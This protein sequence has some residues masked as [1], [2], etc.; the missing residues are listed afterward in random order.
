M[1]LNRRH[2]MGTSAAATALT[3]MPTRSWAMDPATSDKRIIQIFLRGG[4]DGLALVP[5]IG[6]PDYVEARNGIATNEEDTLDLDGFFRVDNRLPTLKALY[7]AGDAAIF[8]AINSP[9]EDRSH[10]DAMN[11]LEMGGTYPNQYSTGWLGRTLQATSTMPDAVSLGSATPPTLLGS[12]TTLTYTPSPLDAVPSETL[13]LLARS[14]ATDPLL[15]QG[16]IDGE[17]VQAI[18]ESVLSQIPGEERGDDSD[19]VSLASLAGAFLAAEEGPR[20][21]TLDIGGWDTHANQRGEMSQLLPLLDATLASLQTNLGAAWTDT[22]I[23]VMSEFGRTVAQNGTAG[24]DHGTGGLALALGGTVNGGRVIADWPGLPVNM[25]YDRDL[26]SPTTDMRAVLKGIIG[27]HLGVS[28]SLLD[29]QVFPGTELLAP[30]DG[31]IG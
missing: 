31:L 29:D 18:A 25:D 22:V 4:A 23:L 15:A 5:P 30:M 17:Q 6:D 21:A 12:P 10:F 1:I 8:Q 13:A 27:D 2:F 14:Y 28:R 24:T 9:Y 3:V 16:L 19:P 7:D 26:L 11:V 20:A